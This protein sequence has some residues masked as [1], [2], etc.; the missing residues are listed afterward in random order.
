MTGF[1]RAEAIGDTIAVTV[2]IRSVNHRHL[3]LA[4]RLPS[5]L[6][7]LELDARRLVQA[8]LERGRVDIGVQLAPAGGQPTQDVRVNEALARRYADQARQ[9]GRDIGL[10][11][12]PS[13]AWVLERPGVLEIAD[14][15]P[16]SPA[17]AWPLLERA[18]A[19]AL[20]ALVARRA[21]E[22]AALATELRGLLTDL[23]TEVDAMATRAPLAS[24]RRG[25]RLRERL[26]ALLGEVPLDESRIV[27]EVAVWAQ[28]TDVA[29]ELARLRAHLDEFALMLDKGGPVG[30]PF[31]FLIQELN[32]EVNTVAAKADDLELSQAALTAKGVIEK[33]REQVQNLE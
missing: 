17:V 12:E 18:L 19:G 26:R 29:E 13:L 11:G 9:V 14:V 31:D 10:A 23:G 32:R 4:L 28:K 16:P 6:A 7:P 8:R 1:G 22:G 5:V 3:D 25:E 20:D 27:T 2:E 15:T 30:R 33:M 24:A 21:A